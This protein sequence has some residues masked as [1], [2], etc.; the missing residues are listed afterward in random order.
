MPPPTLQAFTILIFGIAPGFV[1]IRG[2]SRRR[3]RTVPDRDLYALA[4]AAVISAIWLGFVWLLLLQIGDPARKWGLVPFDTARLE[5][6]REDVV[7]L[8][9]A[10]ICA[11]Y[12]LGSVIAFLMDR[13]ERIATA[14]KAWEMLRGT[15]L[16]KPPT[17]WDKAWLRF[18]RK[19]G[20]G[21]VLVQ[22]RDGLI[23]RGAFGKKSQAALSPN[24]PQL[25]LEE[26]YSYRLDPDG[27][28]EDK[29]LAAVL[30]S[31]D[32]KPRIEAEGPGGVY[33]PGDQINS[34]YFIPPPDE[35]DAGQVE[36][37]PNQ[38]D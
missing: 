31:S 16:F 17:A 4:S 26:G 6:H 1:G 5:G 32:E 15:G 28:S 24:S 22:M 8:G 19:Y 7:L 10:V 14:P 23:V 33:L 25:F 29:G 27:E 12:P 21:E 38:D 18:K 13:L 2:Y 3:Y 9:L 36:E 20:A 11:P 34:V 30:S 35:A 37:P